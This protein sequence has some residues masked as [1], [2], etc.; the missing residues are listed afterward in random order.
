MEEFESKTISSA[1][2]P[3]GLCL[4]NMCNTFVI[5]QVSLG[6]NNT[7]IP[8]MYWKSTHM[9]QYLHWDSNH[10]LTAKYSI[11]STLTQRTTVVCTSQS[12]LEGKQ[13]H[14]RQSLL[15]CNYPSWAINRLQTK[16]NHMFS[17]KKT[18]ITGFRHLIH[19][20]N[21]YKQNI[22]LV[23]PYTR[24]LSESFKKVCNK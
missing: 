12:G 6:P 22:F 9:D 23:E 2:N 16:V 24:G 17:S 4:R 3:P 19:N 8:S 5:K 15:R 7:L 11:F 18:H 14:I 13:K 1:P 20:N 10:I 21:N